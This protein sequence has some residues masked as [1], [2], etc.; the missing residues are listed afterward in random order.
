MTNMKWSKPLCIGTHF[1]QHNQVPFSYTV[2]VEYPAS[3]NISAMVYSVSAVQVFLDLMTDDSFD[4]CPLGFLPVSKEALEG[5]QT[6]WHKICVNRTPT[7]SI[8][9]H[10]WSQPN[11]LHQN[12]LNQ[13]ETWSSVYITITLVGFWAIDITL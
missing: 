10:I 5:E 8:L 1:F 9:S 7:H 4:P 3:L 2:A 11:P 12:Y 13:Q 6:E